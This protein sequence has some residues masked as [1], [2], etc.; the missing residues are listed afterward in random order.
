MVFYTPAWFDTLRRHG[1]AHT[2]EPFQV[3]CGGPVGG[4]VLHLMRAVQ[5]PGLEALSNYYSGLYGPDGPVL[6]LDDADW[7]AVGRAIRQLPH[8]G[9]L[10]LQPLD[11]QSPW[12]PRLEQGLRSAGYWLDRYFCFGNWHQ[13]VAAGGFIA[14]WSERPSALR[15]TVERARR[16]LD[17]AGDWRI[18]VVGSAALPARDDALRMAI[19]AFTAVYRQ[20]WKQPEP[21]E[22]FIPSLIGLAAR[23]GWLRLGVLWFQGQAVASQLWLVQGGKAS[24]YKLAYVAGHERLSAG[25]VLTAALM[26]HVIDVDQVTELDYLSGDDAYKADWMTMRRERVGVVAFHPL[27]VQGW[28]AGARHAAGRLRLWKMHA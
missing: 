4:A 18:D 22:D 6:H 11:V 9:V 15:H 17:R 27:S 8:S 13:P 16:R 3:P 5:G 20:S 21:R 14:Y 1:L 28:L 2:P 24:I 23:E 7:R 26:Q 12:L 19:E 25:S 10:R